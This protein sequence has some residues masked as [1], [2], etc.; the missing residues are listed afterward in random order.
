MIFW[1]AKKGFREEG[2]KMHQK[3]LD[4]LVEKVWLLKKL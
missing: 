3:L 1:G 4:Y 2:V